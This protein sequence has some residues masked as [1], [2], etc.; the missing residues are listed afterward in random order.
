M[1]TQQTSNSKRSPSSEFDYRLR[2]YRPGDSKEVQALYLNAMIWQP[3][4]PLMSFLKL[5]ATTTIAKVI[6]LTSILGAAIWVRHPTLGQVISLVA[7]G[8]ALL[9]LG[10]AFRMVWSVVMQNLKEDLADVAEHYMLVPVNKVGSDNESKKELELQA[11]G[12]RGFWI[13]EATHRATGK[14]ELAG[15]GGLDIIQKGDTSEAEFRRMVVSSRHTRRGIAAMVIGAIVAHAKS[16]NLPS[17][18]LSTSSLQSPAIKLYKKHGWVEERRQEMPTFGT[19]ASIVY[20]RLHLK[21]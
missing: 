17:I 21:E 14:T 18:Y 12:P 13:V 4:A 5:V 1:S 19:N 2:L 6:Y 7:G 20:M 10:F 9:Q 16:H 3:H 8:A 11:S 15:C